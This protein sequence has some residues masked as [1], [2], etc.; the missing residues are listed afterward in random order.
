MHVGP[1]GVVGWKCGKGS[2]TYM[3]RAERGEQREA[4]KDLMYLPLNTVLNNAALYIL[5]TRAY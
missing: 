2:D 1:A 3:Q 4:T 5:Q